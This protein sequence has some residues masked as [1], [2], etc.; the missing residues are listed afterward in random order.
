VHG[1]EET[2]VTK[3]LQFNRL[4]YNLVITETCKLYFQE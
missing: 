1:E 4:C 2:V 3:L